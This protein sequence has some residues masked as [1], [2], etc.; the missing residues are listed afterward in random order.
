MPLVRP[1]D[2]GTD[3]RSLRI[4]DFCHYCYENG[5]FTD[6]DVTMPEMIDRCVTMMTGT[7]GMP[8]AGARALLTDVMPQLKRWRAPAPARSG[9]QRDRGIA[10]GDE[11]C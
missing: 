7:M 2:F 1:E 5:A 9:A 8:E 11:I 6:P 4:N 3:D 10:A